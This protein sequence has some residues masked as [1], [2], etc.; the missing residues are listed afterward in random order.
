MA[1]LN[2]C[3]L[4]ETL[5]NVHVDCSWHFSL[6]FPVSLIVHALILVSFRCSNYIYASV[7]MRRRHT[8]VGLCVSVYLYVC[9][10]HFSKVAKNQALANAVQVQRNN[11]SNLIVLDFWIKALFSSYSVICSPRTLLWHVP[12]FPDDQSTRSGSPCIV[13]LESIQ[14]LQLLTVKLRSKHAI[15]ANWI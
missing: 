14:Q 1:P 2:F 5:N 9:N 3:L 10:S 4:W 12:D 6:Q 15:L 7:R 11:I 13:I 8:V